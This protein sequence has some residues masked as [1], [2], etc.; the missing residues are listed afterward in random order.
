MTGSGERGNMPLLFSI[1]KSGEKLPEFKL[2]TINVT[3]NE[4]GW[5]IKLPKL[6]LSWNAL[7]GIF[8]KPTIF[9]TAAGLQGVGEAGPEAIIPINTLWTE[10]SERLKAGMRDILRGM[11]MIDSESV[12]DAVREAIRGELGSL[13]GYD[14]GARSSA[15]NETNIYL[16]VD[17]K[18]FA[19]LILP[20][21]DR[22]QAA[23]GDRS[24]RL[25][26]A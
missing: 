12:G 3:W 10:M 24:L 6:S 16:Q 19:R 13:R 7:G 25:A 14:A 21:M 15:Q 18:T 11:N 26:G 1:V 9:N 2:P 17:G 4:I 22:E 23:A 5:G 20:Y 8:D